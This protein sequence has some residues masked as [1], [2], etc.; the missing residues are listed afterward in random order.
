M[1]KGK[2]PER[3]HRHSKVMAVGDGMLWNNTSTLVIDTI[4]YIKSTS[5][6]KLL[7]LTSEQA[8]ANCFHWSEFYKGIQWI[9]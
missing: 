2:R 5:L 9:I 8:A 1:G 7:V 4:D 6:L 3:A